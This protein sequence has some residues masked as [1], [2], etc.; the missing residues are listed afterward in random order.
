MTSFIQQAVA[1]MSL[2]QAFRREPGELRRFRRWIG[3]SIRA[4]IRLNWQEQLYPFARDVI[5]A[6]AGAVIFGYG[7]YRVYQ[8][9]FVHPVAD[10]MTVGT[11]IIFMDYTRKLWDPLQWL[12]EF[13]AKV[14]FHVAAPGAC[15]TCSTRRLR[16]PRRRTRA[17]CRS[18]R[19]RCAS[20]TSAS[21]TAAAGRCC[22]TSRPRS[23]RARWSPSSARAAS[24]RARSST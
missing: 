15:S 7:G 18:V 22:A 4:L 14:Q 11:L 19:A 6:V 5:L 1:T 24:A 3:R 21:L 10:A 9:Q 13:V 23:G 20:S 8:D 2:A 12:T 16:S 17:R